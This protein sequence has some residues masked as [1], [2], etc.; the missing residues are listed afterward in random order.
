[1]ERGSWVKAF[2]LC[3]LAFCLPAFAAKPKSSLAYQY[4]SKGV[5]LS[6]HKKWDEALKQFQSAI[7]LNPAFVTSYIEWARASVMAGRRKEGLEK[8]DAAR[9]V[10]RNREDR[11][12]VQRERDALS[13]IFYTSQTFQG[14]QNGL[15]LL[16]LERT[17]NAI[18]AFEQ[19][20]K[21][22][23]DN[24]LVLA[25][26]AKALR[27]EERIKDTVDVL[28]RALL[29]NGAKK[30]V[31]LELAD[32]LLPGNPQRAHEILHVIPAPEFDERSVVLEGQ[33][34]SLMNRNTEALDLLRAFFEK[35]P[36]SLYAPFWLGKFYE[37]EK[38]GAWNS[39]K[40][41]MT[42]IRRAEAQA[43]ALK[44]E[45]TPEAR[46]LRGARL[47]ADQILARVNKSLE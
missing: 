15:N 32:A 37:K 12:R 42:F 38:N 25:A 17:G 10:A 45:N 47:E 22:E 2:F 7:D 43:Q 29:L 44:E 14:Y 16:K 27:R 46:L 9:I 41:L 4:Y 30:E 3:A 11:E 20:L 35:Q 8:L 33:A 24:I 21:V 40:F 18:D 23:P 6:S 13:E 28:E 39:R 19:A 1:M 31:R 26:Y 5:E 36:G 34:L